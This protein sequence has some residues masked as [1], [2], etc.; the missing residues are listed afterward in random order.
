[1]ARLH[2]YICACSLHDPPHCMREALFLNMHPP[3]WHL[4]GEPPSSF[5]LGD[6]EIASTQSRCG[7][8]L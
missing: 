2:K 6:S 1:M 4:I 7:I 5:A 3:Q 8:E